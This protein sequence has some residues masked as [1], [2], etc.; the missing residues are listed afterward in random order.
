MSIQ[1]TFGYCPYR[2]TTL[3]PW[4]A[5]SRLKRHDEKVLA[6]ICQKYHNASIIVHHLS[7]VCSPR[8]NQDMMEKDRYDIYPG[9]D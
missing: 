6:K 7:Q 2:K 4:G 8:L 3:Y 1:F 9:C 5:H